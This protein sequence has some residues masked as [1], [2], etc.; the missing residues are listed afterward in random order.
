MITSRANMCGQ[1]LHWPVEK[2]TNALLTVVIPDQNLI[3]HAFDLP[4]DM[5]SLYLVIIMRKFLFL[6]WNSEIVSVE[7]ISHDLRELKPAW[8]LTGELCV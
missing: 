8:I 4:K 2:D 3:L 5:N 6:P 7:T 1:R